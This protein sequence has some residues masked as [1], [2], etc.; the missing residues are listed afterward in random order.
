MAVND[1]TLPTWNTLD[2][3]RQKF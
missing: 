1:L 3:A 2:E